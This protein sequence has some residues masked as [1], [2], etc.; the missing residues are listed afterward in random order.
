MDLFLIHG[1]GPGEYVR[2]SL[3][4]Q[5]LGSTRRR[6]PRKATDSRTS[7]RFDV[8]AGAPRDGGTPAVLRAAA[9]APGVAATSARPRVD[10]KADEHTAT[11]ELPGG[12]PRRGRVVAADASFTRPDAGAKGTGVGDYLLPVTA[13]RPTRLADS[14]APPAGLSPPAPRRRAGGCGRA[15]ELDKGPGR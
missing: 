12:R 9:S 10:A 1:I 14:A 5:P 6:G 13:D 15:S 3:N 7:R 4:W 2:Q 11:P 8:A